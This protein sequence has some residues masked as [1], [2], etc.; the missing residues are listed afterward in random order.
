M[1]KGSTRDSTGGSLLLGVTVPVPFI[2]GNFKWMVGRI[3]RGGSAGHPLG[4]PAKYRWK[5]ERDE[6]VLRPVESSPAVGLF[7]RNGQWRIRFETEALQGDTYLFDQEHLDEPIYTPVALV[8]AMTV[9][10]Y[11]KLR[12]AAIKR[13]LEGT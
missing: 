13:I 12:D 6:Y 4:D 10:T 11:P 7:R 5:R 8:Y 9:G 3:L 2:G 1:R